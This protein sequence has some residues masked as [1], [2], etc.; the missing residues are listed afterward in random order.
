MKICLL[1]GTLF[2]SLSGGVACASPGKGD[3]TFHDL[4][5]NKCQVK[6]MHVQWDFST[7]LA[8]PT[9]AVSVKW[10]GDEKCSIGNLKL[11]FKIAGDIGYGWV[12]CNIDDVPKPGKSYGQGMA[13]SPGWDKLLCRDD[14]C[15]GGFL[16]EA[17]ARQLWKKGSVIAMEI[18]P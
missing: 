14:K 8:E 10:E 6:S 17:D 7:L 9:R 18:L 12:H 11:A 5:I 16:D 1:V 3:R 2:L 4:V 13:G 15:Q